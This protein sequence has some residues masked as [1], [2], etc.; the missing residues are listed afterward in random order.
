M[1]NVTVI[2]PATAAAAAFSPAWSAARAAARR[3]SPGSED[4]AIDTMLQIERQIDS[5]PVTTLADVATKLELALATASRQG[6]DDEPA[7][8]LVGDALAYLDR[9]PVTEA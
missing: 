6:L 2:I 4:R 8:L 1:S 9:Y 5:A 7:W 3:A